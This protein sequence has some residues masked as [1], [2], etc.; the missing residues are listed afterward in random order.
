M[1]LLAGFEIRKRFLKNFPFWIFDSSNLIS[2]SFMNFRPW[3]VSSDFK[4]L[5]FYGFIFSYLWF[6]LGCDL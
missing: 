4:K 6:G 1:I 3:P 5:N 2:A